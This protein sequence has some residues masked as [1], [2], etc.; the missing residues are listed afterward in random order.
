MTDDW[1]T[2]RVPEDAY[3]EAKAQKEAAGRTWGEQIVRATESEGDVSNADLLERMD[4]LG[5][6][7]RE[8]T[9][10]AQSTERMME[11]LGR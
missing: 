2:L 3:E 5:E 11:D 7:V 4:E 6:S 1:K 10:A 8:A 9:N